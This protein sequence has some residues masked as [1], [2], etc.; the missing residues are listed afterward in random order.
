MRRWTIVAC[1]LALLTFV[2]TASAKAPGT[3]NLYSAK[4]GAAGLEKLTSG[5]YDVAS[6][7]Q[8]GRRTEVFEYVRRALGGSF[9]S[10]V[11][12]SK[13]DYE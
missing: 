13:A 9:V 2:G 8:A 6:L 12:R 4:V 3:L 5:G 1:V 11:V 10:D 7:R